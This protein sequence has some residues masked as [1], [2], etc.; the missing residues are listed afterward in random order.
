MSTESSLVRLELRWKAKRGYLE[1][2]FVAARA[3]LEKLDRAGYVVGAGWPGRAGSSYVHCDA[4]AQAVSVFAWFIGAGAWAAAVEEDARDDGALFTIDDFGMATHLPKVIDRSKG[5]HRPYPSCKVSLASRPPLRLCATPTSCCP[6]L[7][8]A[9]GGVMAQWKLPLSFKTRDRLADWNERARMVVAL[10]DPPG[11][12][13]PY[14]AWAKRELKRGASPIVKEAR[15]L[16]RLVTEETG[17]KVEKGMDL[18]EEWA[19]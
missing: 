6:P 14:G 17:L 9:R 1:P 5:A 12:R 3:T 8:A 4:G 15:E 18:F 2:A 10:M 11:E 13:G 19:P 16:A 7:L